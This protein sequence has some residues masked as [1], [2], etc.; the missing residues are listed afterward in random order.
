MEDTVLPWSSIKTRGLT[1]IQFKQYLFKT[2]GILKADEVISSL[3]L[4]VA[5]SLYNVKKSE[6]YPFEYQRLLREAIVKEI[7]PSDPDE[8]TFRMGL[9]TASWDFSGFLKPLFS[10]I[11]LETLLNKTA[12]L[13]SKYYD[14][15]EMKVTAA[16]KT[17][18]ELEL[19]SFPS[20]QYFC[21]IVTS[22]LKVALEA[23]KKPN[24]SVTHDTCIHKGDSLCRFELSWD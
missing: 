14:K 1:L 8:V 20:D 13:W 6:W 5:D 4:A 12:S 16:R 15:G 7:D 18:A 24:T 2:K 9:T 11:P 19:S 23:L 21:P 10:F 3:P 22:W 17:S